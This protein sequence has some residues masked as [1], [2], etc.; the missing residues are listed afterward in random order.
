MIALL[1]LCAGLL[2]LVVGVSLLVY[3][4]VAVLVLMGIFGTRP[5]RVDDV[6][7]RR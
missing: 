5:S 2:L 3:S 7:R 4:F 6:E 1:L